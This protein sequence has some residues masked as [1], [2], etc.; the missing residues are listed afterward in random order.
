M[1]LISDLQ[2]AREIATF[3]RDV[4]LLL[5]E[6]GRALK[7]GDDEGAEEILRTR[8]REQAA[9]RKALEAS[10]MAGPGKGKPG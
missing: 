5:I 7:C 4:A 1:G 3:G 2:T 6:I 8:N 9:G 10:R